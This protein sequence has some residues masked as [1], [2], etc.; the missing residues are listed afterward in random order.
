MFTIEEAKQH[1][2]WNDQVA[3]EEE[4]RSLGIDRFNKANEKA[5]EKGQETRIIAVR[6]LM[7]DA[8]A[9]TVKAIEE[10]MSECES[11]KAGRKHSAYHYLAAADDV[12]MVAYAAVRTVLDSVSTRKGLTYAAVLVAQCIEDELNYRAFEEQHVA[13]FLKAGV[14]AKKTSNASHRRRAVLGTAEKLGVNLLDWPKRDK[15]LV[16]SKLIELF[17]EATGLA[18]LVLTTQGTKHD[19]YTIEAT[20]ATLEWVE[21]ECKAREWMAPAFMPTLIPPRPWT[22]PFEGGYWTPRVRRLTLVKTPSRAYLQ[23]L[24]NV[25]MPE[26]YTAINALQNTAWTVNTKVLEVMDN[27]WLDHSDLGNIPTADDEA[28]P[29]KPVWLTDEMTK[30]TMTEEQL[31]EFRDWKSSCVQ[32]RE[33]NAKAVADRKCFM[34]ML[35]MAHRFSGKE[36][37]YVYQLDWRGRAYPVGLYLQPQGDDMQRG[38]LEFA[39]VCPIN[40]QE[41]ADWLAI[42]GAGL[43]GVDKV[44]FEERVKWVLD[45]ERE[46]LASAQDPY[47]NRFWAEGSHDHKAEKPWQALAFCFDW[48]A[49][50]AHG[51]GYESALPVQM[52]G[53][54]NGLQNFSAMLLDPIGG[55]AV[56]LL[57]A[58]TPQDIYMRVADIVIRRVEREAADGNELALMWVGNV[59]RK[60]VKRPVMTL[61][62]GARKFG[63][64]DQVFKDTVK[65]WRQDNPA[66]YPFGTKGFEA[67]QYMGHAIWDAVGEVVVAARA[68]MDW[69]QEVARTVSKEGLPINWTTPTGF[70]VQQN[71]KLRDMKRIDIAFQ[72]VRVM[73]SMDKGSEKL[74]QKKQAS[75][76]SP[77]YVHA[78]DAAHMMRT[79]CASTCA[80]VE[81]FSFIHDSYGTHAGN[82]PALATM[83]REEFVRMYSEQCVLTTFKNDLQAMLPEGTALPE[84]PAKGSLD[85]TLV[86]E[87]PFFFA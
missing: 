71:Y 32:V 69:L 15:I 84:I 83:L 34:D 57:P 41:A 10:F 59:K 40:T 72:K 45:H 62:Y 30:E 13:G 46:I 26:V 25:E 86:L 35:S 55:A 31:N 5:K 61:A 9:K 77:N 19:Q 68:A 38:L 66:T 29:T 11:G 75:G 14:R 27:L 3:L 18:K 70:L 36:F 54:C 78:L 42:H 20:P 12:D 7:D 22:S 1:P 16:G 58:E 56:N 28:L 4:M 65:P 43:W 52:D 53:T 63:F 80:G 81:S 60:V 8:H 33:K 24:G 47:A 49:F 23:E 67:A 74:D 51:F 48:A 76:I 6:R 17:V 50:R 2:L 85:L 39:T 44:S 73:L 87:S 37:H 82:C 79:I 21:K 64:T